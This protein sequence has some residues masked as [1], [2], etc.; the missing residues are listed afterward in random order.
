MDAVTV[1][2]FVLAAV[3]TTLAVVAIVISILN[4]RKSTANYNQ[5]KD[6]LA[7]ISSKAAV[8]AESV[9]ETQSKLVDT[10]SEIARPT[11]R[12]QDEM[13]FSLMSTM[14]TQDPDA[15]QKL[16]QVSQGQQPDKS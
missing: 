12:T 4:E 13:I 11:Q 9:G 3:S 10:V 1:I 14:L 5:T 6:V 16:I 2:S 15:I 8:I 7:E